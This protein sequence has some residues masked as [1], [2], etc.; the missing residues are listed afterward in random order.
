MEK[1]CVLNR[2]QNYDNEIF[3]RK[4]FSSNLKSFFFISLGVVI[5]E[6]IYT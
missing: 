6:S 4:K 3:I 1:N 5:E 2:Y